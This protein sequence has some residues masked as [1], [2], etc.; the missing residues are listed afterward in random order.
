VGA[1]KVAFGWWPQLEQMTTRPGTRLGVHDPCV[2]SRLAGRRSCAAWRWHH[3][4]GV[5]RQADAPLSV[6]ELKTRL[7]EPST[8]RAGPFGANRKRPRLRGKTGPSDGHTA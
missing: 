3:A 4:P 7:R 5:P 1:M 6:V 2:K 8:R